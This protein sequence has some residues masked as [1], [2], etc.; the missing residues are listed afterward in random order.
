VS[1][2]ASSVSDVSWIPDNPQETLKNVEN[3]Y[4]AG[5]FAAEMTCSVIKAANRNPVGH[6]YFAIDM[7]VTNADQALLRHV[8]K[9]VMKGSGVLSPVKGAHNLSARGKDR[10]R[11]VLKFLYQYPILAGD[12]ALSRVSLMQE[13]LAYLD[14]HRGASA[15]KAKIEAMDDIR[16]KLRAIKE[17]GLIFQSY[18]MPKVSDDAVGYFLAGVLDSDG[19]FGVKKSGTRRQPYFLV[20]MKDRKIIELCRD[21][22]GHGKVRL[23]TDGLYHYELNHRNILKEVCNTFLTRYPLRHSGQRARLIELQRILN[24]YTRNSVSH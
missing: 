17:T 6:Y 14:T 20:A 23:K 24:D 2:N 16:A 3:Y 5:F 12:S 4:F 10:V 9:V 13:A 7:T 15:H 21:F 19:S 22:L 8:N 1:K 11:T 18:P